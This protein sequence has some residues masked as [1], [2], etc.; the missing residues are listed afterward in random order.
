MFSCRNLL[1][2]VQLMWSYSWEVDFKFKACSEGSNGVHSANMGVLGGACGFFKTHEWARTATYTLIKKTKNLMGGC[3]GTLRYV[4]V[5]TFLTQSTTLVKIFAVFPGSWS[6]RFLS[7][8]GEKKWQIKQVNQALHTQTHKP[9]VGAADSVSLTTPPPPT[10]LCS[11]LHL[12]KIDILF[13]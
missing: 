10:Q 1:P 9:S 3:T 4:R 5:C 2:E 12:T 11:C 6:Q 7:S 8:D 13:I